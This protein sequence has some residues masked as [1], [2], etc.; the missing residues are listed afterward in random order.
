MRSLRPLVALC[1]ALSILAGLGLPGVDAAPGW[2][3]RAS[4]ATGRAG[5][6]ATTLADGQVLV[7]GG[8]ATAPSAERYDPA[9]DRWVAATPGAIRSYHSATRLGD[10]RVLVAGGQGREGSGEA[11]ATTE[12]YLPTTG[13]WAAGAALGAARYGHTATLLP[14]G[15]VFVAGGAPTTRL[16][17]I[18]ASTEIFDP[19]TGRWTTAAPMRVP[20]LG[21]TATL[22][23]D[24]QILVAGGTQGVTSNS[25]LAEVYNPATNRWVDAGSL[26]VPRRG[27]VAVLLNDGQVLVAGGGND[28]GPT[29]TAER[30]D[31][32]RNTWFAVGAM[33]VARYG[34][35]LTLLPDGRVLAAGGRTA[36]AELYDPATERWA[37]APSLAAS[38]EA[39][40]ATLL[41]DGA[42]LVVGGFGGGG[43]RTAERYR[44]PS[45]RVRCFAE[46]GFCLRGRFLAYWEGALSESGGLAL[47]G[48]PL[49]GEFA[50]T[51]ED[52]KVYTVQYFERVRLE[53]HQEN[54]APND[55]LLGQFGRRIHPAD[56][57]LPKPSGPTTADRV[58]FA[59]TGH[60]VGGAFFNYWYVNGGLAQFG[61]PLT[62]EITETLEDGKTYKVQ[63][64]ERA[65]FELHPENAAPYDVLL[66]QFGRKILSG[67]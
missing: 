30:Y 18:A 34:H 23:R 10:G 44:D 48:Y 2:E 62:E 38:R 42:V 56:P 1:L 50:Q 43:E 15:R 25:A 49:S 57:P 65:R 54:A 39:H 13:T 64:F 28:G 21:H 52:G 29:A 4:M 51:L 45:E 53:Y 47:N 12:F 66:G 16:A 58:Y 33:A 9:V 63:Y 46:T 67:R 61:Y 37:A 31:P 5:H 20:R 6:T 60:T 24:G 40:A 14:D 26:I 11:T 59:E 3:P 22:L 17:D 19:A 32:V 8:D 27:Q 35:T 36:I 55:V 41:L 7:V